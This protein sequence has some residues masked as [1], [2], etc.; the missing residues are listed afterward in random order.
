MKKNKEEQVILVKG[1]YVFT[2][3][4]D[5]KGGIIFDGAVAV[6]QEKILEVGDYSELKQKYPNALEEGSEK[7]LVMPGII[8]AHS[9]GQGLSYV[10]RGFAYD[11]LENCLFD[12]KRSVG[13]PDELNARLMAYKHIRNGSTM[14]HVNHY[15]DFPQNYSFD[16]IKNLIKSYRDTGIRLTYS[17]GMKDRNRLTNDDETLYDRLPKDLQEFVSPIMFVDSESIQDYYEALF[18]ELREIVHDDRSNIIMGP[19]WAHGLSDEFFERIR[20][21][22]EQYGGVP[23]HIHTLQTP[24]QKEVGLKKYGKSLLEHL[25]DVGMVDENLTLG[26]AVYLSE[27]DIDILARA[28]ASITHHAS[29]NLYMRNGIAPVYELI[30][31]GVNVALGIDEKQLNDDEDVMQELK[32]IFGLHRMGSYDMEN[33]PALTPAQVM[34]MGTVNAAKTLGMEDKVGALMPG[35]LA[36][37]VVMDLKWI[38]EE[39]WVA[40]DQDILNTVMHRVQGRFVKD[41]M[42]HGEMVMRDYE[43][44]TIDVKELYREVRDYMKVHYTDGRTPE[45]EKYLRVKKYYQELVKDTVHA[46]QEVYYKLNAR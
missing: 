6:C 42:I 46:S 2:D 40:P 43:V 27:K 7:D 35:K 25:D 36:D 1:K 23:K 16:R 10:Q 21:L 26:H 5:P 15:V 41:V 19:Y 30:Q 11:Y 34:S 12:W 18:R 14:L 37:L 38:E 29:C 8:D 13:L 31:K 24:Y 39:P 45:Y 32:M 33:T 4:T 28:K 20:K 44:L 17:T 3:F 22:S 9:H